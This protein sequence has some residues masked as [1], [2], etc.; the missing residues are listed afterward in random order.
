MRARMNLSAVGAWEDTREAFE[1][2]SVGLQ[3]ARERGHDAWASSLANNA[4]STALLLGEW[5]WVVR[6]VIDL[7]LEDSTAPWDQTVIVTLA[8]I[9]AH[10][11][12]LA[13]AAALLEHVRAVVGSL[14]DHQ[15]LT[16]AHSMAAELAFAGGD[17]DTA[18]AEAEEA[19]RIVGSTGHGDDPQSGLIALERRDAA[20]TRA[21][22]AG[23]RG[24]RL[25]DAA[26]DAFAAGARVIDGDRAGLDV[27]DQTI[28][29]LRS[30]GLRYM[31]ACFL[32]A[33]AMLAPDD[34]GAPAA[35]AEAAAIFNELGAVAMLRGLEGL[36]AVDGAP[37][38]EAE[39]AGAAST[40]EAIAA[41]G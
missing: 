17:L 23:Q 28:E 3:R 2:A 11:G 12:R 1:V 29:T 15:L 40:D 22:A 33:R 10:R 8:T 25:R 39:A 37:S 9:H 31:G 5:D 7:G 34:R 6:T 4:C 36:V 35:A 27:L 18:A 13:E 30:A 16:S 38:T 20:G 14:S 32:R 24:G 19:D 26:L 21:A 41:P